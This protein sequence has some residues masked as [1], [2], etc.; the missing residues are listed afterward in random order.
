MLLCRRG[1]YG[2]ASRALEEGLSLAR[3]ARDERA[4]AELLNNLGVV[5]GLREPETAASYFREALDG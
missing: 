2:A 5:A 3:E 4:I 1:N